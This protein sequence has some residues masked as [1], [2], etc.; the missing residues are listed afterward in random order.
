MAANEDFVLVVGQLR[1]FQADSADEVI[2]VIDDALVEPIELGPL[3]Q[4]ES[5]V[6]GDWAEKACGEGG[7][8]SL[9]ELQENEADRIS[10]WQELVAT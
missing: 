6:C 2:E 10:L 3:A 5:T 8:D 9:K 1:G 7:V 4:V